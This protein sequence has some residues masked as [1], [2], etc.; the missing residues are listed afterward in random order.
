MP[1]LGYAQ[2]LG[3]LCNNSTEVVYVSP[4]LQHILQV[5]AMTPCAARSK[6]LET[7]EKLVEHLKS[8]PPPATK[9]RFGPFSGRFRVVFH[10]FPSFSARFPELW[11]SRVVPGAR[12]R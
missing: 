9:A 8:R 2:L 11:R 4:A 5:T 7:L 3:A 6:E 1:R 12:E 10:G